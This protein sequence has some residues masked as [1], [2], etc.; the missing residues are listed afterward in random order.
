MFI[1]GFELILRGEG[2]G[3]KRRWTDF[4]CIALVCDVEAIKEALGTTS[5]IEA[6]QRI[7]SS[8]NH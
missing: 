4:M 1:S 7:V 2:R 5:D 3:R 8:K 6:L